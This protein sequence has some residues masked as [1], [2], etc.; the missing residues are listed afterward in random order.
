MNTNTNFEFFSEMP[1]E[2]TRMILKEC[3]QKELQQTV[4]LIDSKLSNVATQIL[5]DELNTMKQSAQY[6][7]ELPTI[8]HNLMC[9]NTNPESVIYKKNINQNR[10]I[11]SLETAIKRNNTKIQKFLALLAEEFNELPISAMFELEFLRNE[12]QRLQDQIQRFCNFA[13]LT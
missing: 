6:S 11:A 3:T 8:Q 1:L 7:D 9:Y 5:I 13:R 10:I 4:R 2:L 12:Q